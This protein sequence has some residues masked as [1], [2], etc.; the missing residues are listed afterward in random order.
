MVEQC[1]GRVDS[2]SN[3]HSFLGFTSFLR[4]V[5]FEYF[6]SVVLEDLKIAHD[7][8]GNNLDLFIC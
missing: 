7:Q 5:Q 3:E 1:Q 4:S 2:S 6:M 8:A